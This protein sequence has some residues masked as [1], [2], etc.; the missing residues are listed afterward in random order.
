MKTTDLNLIPVFVAIFEERSLS[1][2]AKRLDITQPAVSKALSRLR[3]VYEDTLFNRTRSGVEPTSY[4]LALYPDMSAIINNFNATLSSA[5]DSFEPA[6]SKRSFSIA[7]MHA[8]DFFVLPELFSRIQQ[9]SPGITLVVYPLTSS[10]YENDLSLGKYDL[11]IG[12]RPIGNTLLKHKVILTGQM[13]ACCSSDHPRVDGNTITSE[14]FYAEN[15]V[16]V[17]REVNREHVLADADIKAL[18]KRNVVYN[19]SSFFETFSLIEKTDCIALLPS[20]MESTCREKFSIRIFDLPFKF[21]DI[22]ISM[23]WHPRKNVDAA[24]QWLRN[25]VCTTTTRVISTTG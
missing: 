22:S 5:H 2:A 23:Y 16:A 3:D 18:N 13:K 19:A 12:L 10:D 25:Q 11:I 21:N 14:Q 1:R 15:H 4:A 9:S 8:T 24:H 7:C 17:T 6:K 20:F